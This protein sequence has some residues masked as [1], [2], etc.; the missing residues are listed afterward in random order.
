MRRRVAMPDHPLPIRRYSPN[1]L[2]RS[3]HRVENDA[4]PGLATPADISGDDVEES[5]LRSSIRRKVAVT[6]NAEAPRLEPGLAAG[7]RIRQRM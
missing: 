7:R 4:M 3:E 6:R 1:R 5:L 2:L